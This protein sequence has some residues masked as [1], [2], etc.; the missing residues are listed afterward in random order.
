MKNPGLL[1]ADHCLRVDHILMTAKS[2]SLYL[3]QGVALCLTANSM[4]SMLDGHL[5]SVED[6]Q[7]FH[8]SLKALSDTTSASILALNSVD[9][10][11]SGILRNSL[12]A[13]SQHIVQYFLIDCL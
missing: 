13:V 3:P 10:G 11:C 5:H 7:F 4:S 8:R 6:M 12:R 2:R 1:P 9:G